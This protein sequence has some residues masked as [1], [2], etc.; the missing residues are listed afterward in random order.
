M[1]RLPESR[2]IALKAAQTSAESVFQKPSNK[3]EVFS[4]PISSLQNIERRLISLSIGDC[5]PVK[6]RA[7]EEWPIT[8]QALCLHCAEKCPSVPLPAVKYHD[9]KEDKYWV[10][11]YFC[12]PCCSLAYVQEHPFSDTGRCLLWTQTIL[13]KYFD[14]CSPIVPAPPRCSLIKFGGKLTLDEFYGD[15]KVQFKVVHVPPFVTFAMYVEMTRKVDDDTAIDATNL[16][17]KGLR[18][19]LVRTEP[20]AQYTETGKPPLLLEYLAKRGIVEKDNMM[21]NTNNGEA[22]TKPKRKKEKIA[23][24]QNNTTTFQQQQGGLGKYLV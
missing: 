15:S 7:L 4:T 16:Q 1:S 23:G 5:I 19:P 3:I 20:V 24:V 22:V 17:A 21:E 18:R 9:S 12:R 11:G 13:R 14:I 6:T 8:T 10:Y 2:A